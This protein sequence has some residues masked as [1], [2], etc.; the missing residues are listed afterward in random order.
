M[1]AN[2]RSAQRMI[3]R[4]I[5]AAVVAFLVGGLVGAGSVHVM[6][7]KVR[8]A[9][10]NPA[11]AA[12][13]VRVVARTRAAGASRL[14]ASRAKPLTYVPGSLWLTKEG[15][16]TELIRRCIPGDFEP[17]RMTV[18]FGRD[19]RVTGGDIPDAPPGFVPCAQPILGRLRAPST[20]E[21]QVRS[22]ELL[23]VQPELTPEPPT[24]ASSD[25]IF[26]Q[27]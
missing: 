12:L 5:G 2:D 15:T 16:A 6:G 24:S 23:L 8:S 21:L 20:Q 25:D 22:V 9:Q 19:G 3:G 18:N 17:I 27:R 4:Q 13:L 10:S 7:G 1:A 11:V 14:P 26:S